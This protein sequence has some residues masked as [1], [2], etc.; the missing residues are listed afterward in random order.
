MSDIEKFFMQKVDP[1]FKPW[2]AKKRLF[3]VTSWYDPRELAGEYQTEKPV[4]KPVRK[5][6]LALQDYVMDTTCPCISTEFCSPAKLAV[7]IATNFDIHIKN[8]EA[9]LL[10]GQASFEKTLDEAYELLSSWTQNKDK[11]GRDLA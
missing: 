9:R 5:V 3:Y 7:H 4:V 10:T 2:A 1:V 6:F 8:R 11:S